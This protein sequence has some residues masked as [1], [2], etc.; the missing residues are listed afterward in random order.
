M[1]NE[2]LIETVN[3]PLYDDR[4]NLFNLR[5]IEAKLNQ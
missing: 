3:N 5:E 2:M 1:D 4:S